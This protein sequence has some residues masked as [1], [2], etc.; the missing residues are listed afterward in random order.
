MSVDKFFRRADGQTHWYFVPSIANTSAPTASEINAGLSLAEAIN[1]V[2]GWSYE[3]KT[4]DS[5]DFSTAFV[6]SI[7][8]EDQAAASSI[9]LYDDKTSS[10]MRDALGKGTEGYVVISP[11]AKTTASDCDVWKVR[12]ASANRQYTM[13]A[14]PALYPIM[15]AIL[16]RPVQD[17]TWPA[18]VTS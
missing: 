9:T 3:N 1:D 8:G 15:F 11:Y 6:G 14:K 4:I 16:D 17:A 7:D 5:P 13:D 10:T 2:S 18:G 12:V